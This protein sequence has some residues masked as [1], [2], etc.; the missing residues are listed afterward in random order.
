MN[1][2]NEVYRGTH[3]GAEAPRSATRS[4]GGA[5]FLTL[6]G[7]ECLELLRSFKLIWVPIVFA[8]LGIM[9]PVLSYYMPIIIEKAGNMPE[10]TVIEI[11][12]PMGSQVLA[13]TLSQ[14]GVMGILI[15]ALACMGIVSGE[16]NSG[17]SALVL[18]KPVSYA[19]YILSKWLSIMLLS[20]GSLLLGYGAAWYYT[21]LLIEYVDVVPFLLS[22]VLYGLWFSFVLTV[23]LLFSTALRSAAGAAFTSLGAA[24]LLTVLAGLIPK[25]MAWSPGA[26]TGLAYQAATSPGWLQ[27]EPAS[28]WAVITALIAIAA[29]L[30]AS[31]VLLKRAPAR[32]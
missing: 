1:G 30:A 18:V 22:F 21:W 31:V 23:T 5:V 9:Q 24:I 8:V 10:G 12:A 15:L 20:W 28:W 3:R 25:Y 13:D 19:S 29:L 14:F 27:M 11:P 4:S 6:L 26:L 17:A 32:D 16:R 7:K 2:A